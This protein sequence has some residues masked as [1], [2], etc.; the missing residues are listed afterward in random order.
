MAVALNVLC[1]VVAAIMLIFNIMFASNPYTC[2]I[3]GGCNYL[4]YTYAQAT[5]FYIGELVLDLLL[6]A[7]S[8]YFDTS[9]RPRIRLFFFL[10]IVYMTLFAKFGIGGKSRFD[11][12]QRGYAPANFNPSGAPNFRMPPNGRPGPRNMMNRG[13][14]GYNPRFAGQPPRG[15]MS[16]PTGPA[17]FG[18]RGPSMPPRGPYPTLGR[19][20]L[21]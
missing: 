10:A 21:N 5:S 15:M 9:N 14:P 12:I 3:A 16:R 1:A 17:A 13:P 18:P 4:K 19:P 8:E 11:N 7:T 2:I 20:N 6:I